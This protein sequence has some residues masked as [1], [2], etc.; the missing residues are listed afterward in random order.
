[1]LTDDQIAEYV[2]NVRDGGTLKIVLQ[3]A[4]VEGQKDGL[5]QGKEMFDSVMKKAGL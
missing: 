2:K 3:L 5:K 4:Y 1:M